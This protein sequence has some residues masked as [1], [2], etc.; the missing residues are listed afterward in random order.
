[1]VSILANGKKAETRVYDDYGYGRQAWIAFGADA[2]VSVNYSLRSFALGT[3]YVDLLIDGVIRNTVTY[4]SRSTDDEPWATYH[5]TF[6]SASVTRGGRQIQR[7]MRVKQWDTSYEPPDNLWRRFDSERKIRDGTIEIRG[8]IERR[9]RKGSYF[10]EEKYW[11]NFE[12]PVGGNC[13]EDRFDWDP[14]VLRGVEV[15]QKIIFVFLNPR[16]KFSW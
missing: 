14:T 7:E 15:D 12:Y 3:I 1:M 5:G 6:E 4:Q 16:P 11:D 8:S 13:Y 9:Q 2:Q 10:P